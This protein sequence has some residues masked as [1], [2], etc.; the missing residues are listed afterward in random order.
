MTKTA[1]GLFSGIAVIVLTLIVVALTNLPEAEGAV[2]PES[3]T[4]AQCALKPVVQDQGYG[5]GRTIQRRVC[6]SAAA[7]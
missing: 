1:I 2:P 7:K 6:E 4:T 5:I 3:A